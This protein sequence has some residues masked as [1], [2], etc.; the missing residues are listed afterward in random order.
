MYRF[1]IDIKE[2]AM[3]RNRFD[4]A[5]SNFYHYE[6]PFLSKNLPIFEKEC[7]SECSVVCR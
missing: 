1:K 6:G 3:V 4:K 5:L 2:L 7:I